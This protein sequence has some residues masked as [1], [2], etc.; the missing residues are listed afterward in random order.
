MT[1]NKQQAR[2]AEIRER[3]TNRFHPKSLTIHDDSQLHLGHAAS[4]EGLGHF[5]LEIISD[6]F[7]EKSPLECHKLIYEAL[8]DLMQTDIH[9]L[10]VIR[11]KAPN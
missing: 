7:A 10:R 11:A 9:A 4:K 1:I 2:I 8:G 5:S 3:L 6:V